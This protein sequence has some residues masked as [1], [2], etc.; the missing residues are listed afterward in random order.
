MEQPAWAGSM[1]KLPYNIDVSD[2]NESDVTLVEY[3][4]RKD[5]LVI[6]ELN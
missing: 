5:L 2:S 4:G 6:M 1:L 3:I